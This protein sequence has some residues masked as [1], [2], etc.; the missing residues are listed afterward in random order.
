MLICLPLAQAET[1]SARPDV[2][3][4]IERISRAQGFD[5]QALT[6]LL[7]QA[8]MQPDILTAIARPA[9]AKP[10]YQYR[11]LFLTPQRI[12]QG[13]AF[14]R[15][16]E[17]LLQ[18]AARDYQVPP[19]I[20][21]AILGVETRY[22]ALQG[23]YRVLDALATL[24][25]G[26]PPRADFF[27]GELTEFLLLTRD[28]HLVVQDVLGS[29]AGAMG[30][31]QFIPSSYRRLAIDFDGDGQRNLW[32]PADAIGSI[33]NYFRKN[34]WHAGEPVA[35]RLAD[36]GTLT[37]DMDGRTLRL[38]KRV[39][40]FQRAGLIASPV[41]LADD[42]PAGLLELTQAEGPEYWLALHNFEVST[43]Y[44]RSI[45]YAMAVYQLSEEIARAHAL[46]G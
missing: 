30:M 21:V 16:N 7:G 27:R 29:Y 12:D 38:S 22:G 20:I 42:A 32:Q 45:L 8:R 40:D 37:S 3:A 9:E 46:A 35:L 41:G 31:A 23:R 17:A 4:Y 39:R 18:R 11:A 15:A 25:F 5:P 43:K 28:E 33:A 1:F 10:W 44:N 34:G 2:Q 14:W 36:R 24:G 13:V 26:Y 6:A 19:Q